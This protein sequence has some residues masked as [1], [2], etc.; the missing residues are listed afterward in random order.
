MD[1]GFEVDSAAV[2]SSISIMAVFGALLVRIS[3]LNRLR[4][5]RDSAAGNLR[6][7]KIALLTGNSDLDS[8]ERAATAAAAAGQEYDTAKTIIS[9]NGAD[10]Q[11][12]NRIDES[13]PR[14]T[15]QT[16][17]VIENS[18]AP[19]RNE[20]L[21]MTQSALDRREY[22][23]RAE[24]HQLR[25][26]G[27][28]INQPGSESENPSS[29]VGD[30][31]FGLVLAPLLCLFAFSLTPDPLTQGSRAA[32]DPYCDP[33][34]QLQIQPNESCSAQSITGNEIFNGHKVDVQSMLL[35][36]K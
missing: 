3:G 22:A 34:V 23:G 12:G 20:V 17:Q 28:A 31:L 9:V 24:H 29:P 2:V 36:V 14:A 25:G 10:V 16:T 7:A 27:G 19:R 6:A 4:E 35:E 30:V 13:F 8:F 5:R 26:N 32:F 15:N 1:M 11:I 33:C 18:R 21:Q